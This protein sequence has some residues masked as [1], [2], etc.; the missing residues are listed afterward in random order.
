MSTAPLLLA[1]SFT[2]PFH[3]PFVVRALL[4]AVIAGALCGLLSVYI[5]LRGMSYLGHGLSHSIFGGAAV[6]AAV[7]VNFVVGAGVWGLATGLAIGRVTK[8]RI[9]GSDAAIGV[10]TTAS[11]A[12]GLV[13][14]SL[15]RSVNRSIDATLF[16][17][18]LGVSRGD[19]L[20]VLAVAVST[21]AFVVLS[22]RPLL[23]LTFDPDVAEVSGVRTGWLD[24][25]LM[26]TMSLAVLATMQVLGVTLIAATLV[27]PSVISRLLT[28]SFAPMLAISTAIGAIGGGVGMYLSYFW[29]TP[30]GP[31]IVLAESALFLVVFLLGG[32]RGRRR[33]K[34]FAAD[35]HAPVVPG[36]GVAA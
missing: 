22:Y 27:T 28:N 35:H 23:F 13:L 25:G 7:G 11:F 8:R 16:G 14:K 29:D 6:S 9:I 32:A 30:S 36:V 19:V 3:Q 10:I 18:I 17:S 2:E 1:T 5:T 12:L 26:L 20:L 34:G 24:A 31:T 15:I 4:V 21:G 33:L